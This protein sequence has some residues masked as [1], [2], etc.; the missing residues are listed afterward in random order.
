MCTRKRSGCHRAVSAIIV[1]T[2]QVTMCSHS[3][4]GSE[5]VGKFQRGSSLCT[6][7]SFPLHTYPFSYSDLTLHLSSLAGAFVFSSWMLEL[8]PTDFIYLLERNR[9]VA[10]SGERAKEERRRGHSQQPGNQPRPSAWVAGANHQSYYLL[11]LSVCIGRN[12][13]LGLT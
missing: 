5:R 2:A 13:E 7:N 3:R 10:G 1:H 4:P 9:V 12:L 6:L 8:L 11:P